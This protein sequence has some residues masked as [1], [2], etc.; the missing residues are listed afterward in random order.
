MNEPVQERVS[1]STILGEVRSNVPNGRTG[2]YSP[3]P[4]DYPFAWQITLTDRFIRMDGGRPYIPMSD[5]TTILRKAAYFA[6]LDKAVLDTIGEGNTDLGIPIEIVPILK[7]IFRAGMEDY[8]ICT[9]YP[10][11][12]R[13]HAVSHAI[14]KMRE[15]YGK[16]VQRT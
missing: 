12:R 5:E 6:G 1:L 3:I 8:L 4:K 7:K 2:G 11:A 15:L 16:P 9:K 14:D 13:A 10:N